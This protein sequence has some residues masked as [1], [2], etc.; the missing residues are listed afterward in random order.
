MGAARGESRWTPVEVGWTEYHDGIL[1]GVR[2]ADT[3]GIN[4]FW[5]VV[6]IMPELR[7]ACMALVVFGLLTPSQ[8]ASV[9][10]P[11]PGLDAY[12]A[13]RCKR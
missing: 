2:Q 3:F 13:Q 9:P 1:Y 5:V 6:R 12:I 11:F 10:E 7:V 4:V 8:N